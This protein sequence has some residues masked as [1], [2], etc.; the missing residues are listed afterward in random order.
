[1]SHDR[2][3][4]LQPGQLS[5]TLS[6]KK[7]R[8]KERRKNIWEKRRKVVRGFKIFKYFWLGTAAH[9]CNHSTLGGFRQEDC[10]S[11]GIRD[12]PG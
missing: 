10:L 11:P 12:Q 9:A 3:S 4:V 8:K 7:E 2:A 5:E 1:M 6:Q